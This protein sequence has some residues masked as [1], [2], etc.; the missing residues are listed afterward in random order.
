MSPS[1]AFHRALRDR[2]VLDAGVTARVHPDRIVALSG[3]PEKPFP[4][5]LIDG[6]QEI[7]IGEVARR[8]YEVFIDCHVWS[9][10][11]STIEAREIGSA[12]VAAVNRGLGHPAG[13]HIH[14]SRLQSA[15]YLRDPGGNLSHGIVTFK[16][17]VEIL[18]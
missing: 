3:L 11:L 13:A 14:D 7:P 8:Y 9:A 18:P 12:L 10:D 17:I 4:R 6:G 2:F 5:V 1:L 16:G 15:R